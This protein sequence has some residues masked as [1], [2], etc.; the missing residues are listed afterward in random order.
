[1]QP[2]D[3]PAAGVLLAPVMGWWPSLVHSTFGL[4]REVVSEVVV[5]GDDVVGVVHLVSGMPGL[6]DGVLSLRLAVAEEARGAGIGAALWQRALDV[7]PSGS[8]VS[9]RAPADDVRSLAIAARWG[10][11]AIGTTLYQSRELTAQPLPVPVPVPRASLEV[12]RG[13]LEG[14]LYGRVGA[15]MSAGS[16][17]DVPIAT[18]VD[19]DG[20]SGAFSN[21]PTMS[22]MAAQPGEV[23]AVFAVAED[24]DV[25]YSIAIVR[26][27]G[28][29]VGDTAVVPAW[30]RR[31]VAAWVKSELARLAAEDGA[32][33]LTTHND[34]DNTPILALNEASGFHV[35][36]RIVALQR[37]P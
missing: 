23:V 32:N 16:A 36:R 1:M 8:T 4:G 21:E 12:E 5:E 34:G 10:F 7:M 24:V 3:L 18:N 22:I 2:A 13:K 17:L 14:E 6:P 26:E 20:T 30:R 33:S 27:S 25:G 35:L 15:A 37:E 31:G 9:G 29:H 28:W 11:K 19:P